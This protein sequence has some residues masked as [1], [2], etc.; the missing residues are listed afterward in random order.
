MVLTFH[1]G[2]E[3]WN[4]SGMI[5]LRDVTAGQSRFMPYIFLLE[6]AAISK[7]CFLSFIS[8]QNMDRK[9]QK[10]RQGFRSNR[11]RRVHPR[12]FPCA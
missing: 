8:I 1:E 6:K 11:R 5:L 12:K 7:C 4:H 3:K 2:I 9:R 10:F